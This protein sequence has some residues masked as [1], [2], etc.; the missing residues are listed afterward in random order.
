MSPFRPKKSV[1]ARRSRYRPEFLELENRVVPSVSATGHD[2]VLPPAPAASLPIMKVDVETQ[3]LHTTLSNPVDQHG[4][5]AHGIG[6][7]VSDEVQVLLKGQQAKGSEG[8]G[9]E[10]SIFIFNI[11]PTSTGQQG[12]GNL[13]LGDPFSTQ[14]QVLQDVQ[15]ANG[16]D[17]LSP[18][19][20]TTPS[21]LTNQ[22]EIGDQ[23][24]GVERSI[25]TQVVQ[26]G[27][28]AN[29]QEGIGQNQTAQTTSNA[30]DMQ[31][32]GSQGAG[33]A[34][35]SITQLFADASK[36]A[37]TQANNLTLMMSTASLLSNLTDPPLRVSETLGDAARTTGQTAQ[38]PLLRDQEIAFLRDQ[39]SARNLSNYGRSLHTQAS[40]GPDKTAESTSDETTDDSSPP[41]E[42]STGDD[43]ELSEITGESLAGLLGMV[44][45]AMPA[46]LEDRDSKERKRPRGRS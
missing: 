4:P 36:A 12:S 24:L 40:A 20:R 8:I 19:G 10:I 6:D 42:Q 29:A 7:L 35:S 14:M 37:K 15:P 33:G 23:G 38:D 32:T 41:A 26:I 5:G 17:Q 46:N 45:F 31:A 16:L 18:F 13:G 3:V 25:K 22:Q 43:L 44:Y 28:R 9:Q 34:L 27:L 1:L 2:A 30:A 11:F 21:N 39:E